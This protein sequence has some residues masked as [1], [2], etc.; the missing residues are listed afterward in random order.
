MASGSDAQTIEIKDGIIL[1]GDMLKHVI[2]A[3]KS[4]QSAGFI[5][6]R[7]HHTMY[8]MAINVS[9]NICQKRG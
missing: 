8:A 2:Q 1:L 6:A 7:F 4:N 5:G 3:V 9:K